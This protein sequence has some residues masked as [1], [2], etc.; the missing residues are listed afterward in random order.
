MS[1]AYGNIDVQPIL[2]APVEML[3]QT[4]VELV[5][6][7]ALS[8]E[9]DSPLSIDQPGALEREEDMFADVLNQVDSEISQTGIVQ[10]LI[11]LSR[12]EH[13][14]RHVIM[15]F[16]LNTERGTWLSTLKTATWRVVGG[17]VDGLV[18]Q[19]C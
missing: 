7:G 3:H 14:V 5:E 8:V 2:V 17:F 18:M 11:A 1:T 10:A 9:T 15:A 4:S 13:V 6:A 16:R 19:Q 12:S